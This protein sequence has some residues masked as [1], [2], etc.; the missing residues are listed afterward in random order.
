MKCARTFQDR[1]YEFVRITN[2]RAAF[3]A[4]MLTELTEVMHIIHRI[5]ALLLLQLALD[6]NYQAVKKNSAGSFFEK[7]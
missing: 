1:K 4:R 3:R 5:A 2:E 6:A 7:R